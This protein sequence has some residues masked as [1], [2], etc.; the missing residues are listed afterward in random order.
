[1]LSA[2]PV[3][4]AM[5]RLLNEVDFSLSMEWA[6]LLNPGG[7]G[8]LD[9]NLGPSSEIERPAK[10]ILPGFCDIFNHMWFQN[11]VLV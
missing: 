9:V 10:V 8:V 3:P 7:G 11:K 1:M 4:N 5:A 2:S 6:E